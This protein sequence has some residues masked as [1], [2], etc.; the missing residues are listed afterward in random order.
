M[1]R[2]P[3]HTIKKCFL[4]SQSSMS[5]VNGQLK[6]PEKYMSETLPSEDGNPVFFESVRKRKSVFP[7]I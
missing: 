3:F 5:R 7:K 1:D 6:R 2:W 4:H